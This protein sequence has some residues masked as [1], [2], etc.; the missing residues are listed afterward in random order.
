MPVLFCLS[1]GKT[2]TLG[3]NSGAVAV[4]NLLIH[5]SD[6]IRIIQIRGK[7]SDY[8]EI[9][10]AHQILIQ[11]RRCQLKC[12]RH[13]SRSNSSIRQGLANLSQFYSDQFEL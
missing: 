2:A 9:R 5:N 13:S 7:Y 12:G 6:I 4:V 8:S 10:R 3:H 11:R 1:L